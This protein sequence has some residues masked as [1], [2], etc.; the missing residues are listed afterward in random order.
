MYIVIMYKYLIYFLAYYYYFKPTYSFK[1]KLI[2]LYLD[3]L[4]PCY[5]NIL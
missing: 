1:I 5:Y 4:E 3:M 2:V